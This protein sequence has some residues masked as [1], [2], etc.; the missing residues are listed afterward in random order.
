MKRAIHY[1]RRL[2]ERFQEWRLGI[3]TD[4]WHAVID[5]E[6]PDRRGYS[7]TSYRG[8]RIIRRHIF[9]HGRSAFIDYG[10]GLGRVTILAALLPFSR[11][12]GVEVFSPSG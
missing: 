2:D 6:H 1:L 5:P 7:P 9:V 8:W 10:A 4:E 3:D 11:V 12:I